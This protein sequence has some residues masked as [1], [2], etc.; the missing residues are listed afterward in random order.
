M[1]KEHRSIIHAVLIALFGFIAVAITGANS[2]TTTAVSGFD[3]CGPGVNIVNPDQGQQVNGNISVDIYVNQPNQV[4]EVGLLVGEDIL[5]SADP[6]STG[7]NI[8]RME[9]GTQSVDN[10]SYDLRAVIYFTSSPPCVTGPRQVNVDNNSAIAQYQLHLNVLPDDYWQGPTNVTFPFEV[11][12]IMVD[13]SG[14]FVDNVTENT[15]FVWSTNRGSVSSAEHIGNYFSGPQPGN[16]YIEI[17]ASYGGLYSKRKIILDIFDANDPESG[18]SLND[19]VGDVTNEGEPPESNKE[20]PGGDEVNIAL[21]EELNRV[22]YKLAQCLQERLGDEDYGAVLEE[23]QRLTDKQFEDTF[24]CFSTRRFVIPASIAPVDPDLVYGLEE[25]SEIANI[26]K[27][28][29]SF[30]GDGKTPKGIIFSGF[31]E[32]NSNILI[33]VFSEPLVL[34]SQTD[35]DGRWTYTLEDPLEPGEHEAYVLVDIDEGYVRS[36]SFGFEVAKAAESAENPNG[37]SLDIVSS[38]DSSTLQNYY[39]YGLSLLLLVA[40]IVLARFVWFRKPKKDPMPQAVSAAKEAVGTS[41]APATSAESSLS[42]TSLTQQNEN[43]AP[44]PASKTP[45]EPALPPD[46]SQPPQNS[47][48]SDGLPR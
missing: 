29:Q 33:Y 21:P 28:E 9:W 20:D 46:I 8:W 1:L 37:Y 36:S 25:R 30:D 2:T 23:R 10:G 14:D 24:G 31:A 4:D 47:D 17:E 12:A 16:G 18:G 43:S 44:E 27:H 42:A 26:E 32:P 41:S 39:L 34:S 48:K 15:N 5:G 35:S 13:S 40:S 45:V 11:R 38:S 19:Y 3:P 22:D 7:S 6:V